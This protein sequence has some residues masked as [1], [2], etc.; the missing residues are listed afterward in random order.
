ML[1]T[2]AAMAMPMT[3]HAAAKPFKLRYILSSAMYGKAPI[4]A[5]LGEVVKTGAAH[6]DIWPNPH[7]DHYEQIEKMGFDKFG[8][9]LVKHDVKL[10]GLASYRF[11]PWGLGP[12]LKWIMSIGQ[13]DV[14]LVCTGRG[15]KNATGDALKK[16]G[17]EFGEKLKPHAAAAADAHCTIAIENHSSNLIHTPD[18]LKWLAEFSEPLGSVGIAFAP[19]HLHPRPG[20]EQ[21]KLIEQ[22][23]PA[24]RFVY[25]QQHGKGSRHTQPKAD[26]LLQ[27]PGR[28][29]L[30][31]APIV[32]ALKKIKYTGFTEIF[33]HPFPRGIPILEPRSAVTD[34]INRSRRYLQQCVAQ[35]NA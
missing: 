7:A 33:M 17:R 14:A 27:M 29:P 11:G 15:P 23:G 13:R 12:H 22:L 26:E 19:H 18:S 35:A 24:I 9:L 25:A 10:G 32:A 30:D 34:E 4:D 1:A 16:A 3:G 21:A 31:F 28:G 6:I 20:K 8:A 5:V 2:G